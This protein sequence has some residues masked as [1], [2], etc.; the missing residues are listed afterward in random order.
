MKLA[1]GLWSEALVAGIEQGMLPRLTVACS[2]QIQDALPLPRQG[3]D[4]GK[5]EVAVLSICEALSANPTLGLFSHRGITGHY[6][7]RSESE[8]ESLGSWILSSTWP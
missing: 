3:G 8:S 7:G 1:I 4:A 6:V 2:C 5:T